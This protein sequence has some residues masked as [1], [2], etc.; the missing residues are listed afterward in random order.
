MRIP[1]TLFLFYISCN[2]LLAQETK[3]VTIN[4]DHDMK[5]VYSVLKS[6][7]DIKHGEYRFYEGKRKT[8][9][10]NYSNNK[11]EGKWTEYGYFGDK[12]KESN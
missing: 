8:I 1:I 7:K 2:L 6:D 9:E 3:E 5:E 12:I 4:L 11:K 10:G